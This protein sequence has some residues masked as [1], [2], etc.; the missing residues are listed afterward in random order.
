MLQLFNSLLTE[1]PAFSDAYPI[2]IPFY[3]ILAGP[4]GTDA[5]FTMFTSSEVNQHIHRMFDVW[6]SFLT[7]LESCYV[8]T[9]EDHGWFSPAAQKDM[10]DFDQNYQCEPSKQYHGF[11]CWDG[12][13]TRLFREGVRPVAFKDRN[14]IVNSACEALFYNK[15]EK[16]KEYST[17]WLK[18]EPYSLTHM[19]NNDPLTSQFVGGTVYQS[20]LSV[21]DYHR[22]H[23]PVNGRIVKTV[24]IPGTYYAESPDTKDGIHPKLP[25]RFHRSQS[26]L[27]AVAARAL[28]FIEADSPKIGLM[29]FMAVG[30]IEVSTC[31]ITVWAGNRVNKGDQLGMFHY[32]GST[33]CLVFRPETNITFTK[34]DPKKTTL[35]N[36]EIG[37]VE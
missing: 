33:Y 35:L 9:T 28:I 36:E 17:F 25:S 19:F 26:F 2:A 4:L 32:G 15:A 29:C 27:T 18:G 7:S 14:D 6:A 13:F 24:L 21:F 3:A 10:P 22:W 31:E 23:S 30:M 16:V 12:F 1:A 20:F 8:L 34:L 11:T 5:G 37:Y